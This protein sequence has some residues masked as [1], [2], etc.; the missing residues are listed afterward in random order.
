MG[1]K[2]AVY[3]FAWETCLLM[4][5]LTFKNFILTEDKNMR[6][7]FG[8]W[9]MSDEEKVRR[10]RKVEQ[11]QGK[12]VRL[13]EKLKKIENELANYKLSSWAND[14]SNVSEFLTKLEDITNE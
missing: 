4:N 2:H 3:F 12:T 14:G 9:F 1:P 8:I 11:L 5:V 10:Q 6:K 7:I 13:E